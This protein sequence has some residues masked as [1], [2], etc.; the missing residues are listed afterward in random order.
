MPQRHGEERDG[1]RSTDARAV[2]FNLSEFVRLARQTS[3]DTLRTTNRAGPDEDRDTIGASLAIFASGDA[4]LRLPANENAN[5]GD[6]DQEF[7][8]CETASVH[9]LSDFH[10]ALLPHLLR[11]V[12]LHSPSEYSRFRNTL[13]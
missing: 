9:V 10:H 11:Q 2:L 12:G 5:N 1:A 3:C 8:Q 13:C 6:H 7:N 4:R